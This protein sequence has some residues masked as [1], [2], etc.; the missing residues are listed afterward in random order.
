MNI[1]KYIYQYG[2]LNLKKIEN[3]FHIFVY[4]MIS[5]NYNGFYPCIKTDVF[6]KQMA[7]LADNFIV[8]SLVEIVQR[9]K[10]GKSLRNCAIIT[11]DD[12]FMDNYINAFPTLKRLK[13]P[14]TIFLSTGS[15]D[16]RQPPWFIKI[17]NAFMTTKRNFFQLKLGKSDTAL[18]MRNVLER[19]K[20][21]DAVMNFLKKCRDEERGYWVDEINNYLKGDNLSNL[22][23]LMLDWD[24]VREMAKDQIDFGAHT[25]NHPVMSQMDLKDAKKEIL[26]SKRR[27]EDEL[28]KEVK[29]F[30]YPFGRKEDYKSEISDIL[31][32]CNFICAVTTD[33]GTN[34]IKSNLYELKR[35]N[36]WLISMLM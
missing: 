28:E 25:V 18:S 10:T 12:G 24:E 8:V 22:K 34:S 16:S 23:R 32:E 7:Y 17:R 5:D 4:H 33:Q 35:V 6:N 3:H 20:A 36:P 26:E 27:I 14:A 9:I 11:F 30:A 31:R 1:T 15:I 19:V 29:A 2:Y 13:L 21:S